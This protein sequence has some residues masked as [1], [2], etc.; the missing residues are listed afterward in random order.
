M[1]VIQFYDELAANY[2]LIF[3]DWD[4]AISWNGKTL[5]AI[6][7]SHLSNTGTLSLYDCSCG[8]G[9]QALGLAAHDY[10]VYATDISPKAVERA[11]REAEARGVTLCTGVAEFRNLRQQSTDSYDVVISCDNSLPHLLTDD[12]LQLATQNMFDVLNP[13]GLLLISIRD[14]DK[15]RQELPTT[16]PLRVMGEGKDRYISFQVWDWDETGIIYTVTQFML[17]QS[18]ENQWQAPKTYV[19]QY[20]ALQRAE[21]NE[22]L[23][24]AGFVDIRWQMPEESGYYQPIVTASRP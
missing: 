19:T 23:L 13:G 12:D 1:T 4:T 10:Q 11:Q 2:H 7:R 15:V 8:I 24:N 22:L 18:T 6:I 17:T 3:K 14:Y 21:L 16:D 9:T 20:R 5:D